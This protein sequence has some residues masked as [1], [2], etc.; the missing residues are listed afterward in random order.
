M[1][2]I[3]VDKTGVGANKDDGESTGSGKP[4]KPSTGMC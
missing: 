1:N 3:T 2:Y 4:A